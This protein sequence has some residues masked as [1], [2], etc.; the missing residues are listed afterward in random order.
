[1]S[2]L[3]T[4]Q[5]SSASVNR[6]LGLESTFQSAVQGTS[7]PWQLLAAIAIR[8]T[9]VLNTTEVDG[10]GV[11]VGI[12][13][14]TVSPTSG[15]TA[16]QAGNSTFAANWAATLLSNNMATLSS[17]YPNLSSSQLLQATAASFN[18]GTGNISGNPNTIDVGSA[19]NNYG[20]NVLGLI[21]CFPETTTQ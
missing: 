12:F 3:G 4:A 21:N 14:I 15:V 18:F 2:A 17:E 8:E 5:K 13:Q 6:A 10:A 7:I 19:G 16:A 1:M 9:G 20:S 11:G